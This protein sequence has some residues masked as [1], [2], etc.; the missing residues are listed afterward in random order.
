MKHDFDAV[1]SRYGTDSL[2]FDFIRDRGKPPDILPMWVAD[3]D[4]PAPPE[5]LEDIQKSVLHG[6]FG[7]T[8]PT[9]GYYNAVSDW[10]ASR[11]GYRVTRHEIVKAPGVVFALA[12]IVRAFTAPGDAIMIQ[13]PVYHP[14]Y[15]L[16]RDNGRALVTNPLRYGG[17]KYFIDFEDFERKIVQNKVKLFLL[18]SPHNPVGRVW[19]KSELDGLN[20]ICS[21]YGVIVV[22]DEIH[23]DF[24]WDGHTHTCFGLLDENAVIATAPSK[25][26]NLAGLQA[27][28]IF[29]KN[30]KLR[31]KL[32][33]EIKRSGYDNLNTLGLAACKS[34][35][36]HG[37]AWLDDLR[38]YLMANIRLV[39][40]FLAQRLSKIKP[41]PTE[42]TYLMWLD[43]SAYGLGQAE[44]DRRMTQEAKLWLNSGTMF[45]ADGEGF[46]RLNVAC[47]RSVLTDA[48]ARL[49][50]AAFLTG[51]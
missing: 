4:F 5:V 2:K 33:A 48:L 37:G 26:F 19:T 22:S 13:T 35:Y 43:F 32:S 9:D 44:L 42:G 45:G 41:V 20:R 12:Q 17:G 14:F 25:T 7:Y 11:F 18:C 1:I 30:V 21:K 51:S 15:S 23:C 50:K 46:L 29:I 27:S 10:F 39:Q 8:E 49:E 24:V 40:D 47:P 31:E 16:I 34:A 3:M 6:I 28:N 36:T 38:A